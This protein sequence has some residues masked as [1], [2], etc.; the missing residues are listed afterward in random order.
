MSMQP[1]NIISSQISHPVASNFTH[2]SLNHATPS[3][4]PMQPVNQPSQV[5][6]NAAAA[7][8][9]QLSSGIGHRHNMGYEALTINQLRADQNVSGNANRLLNSAVQNVPPL[10]PLNDMGAAAVSGSNSSTNVSTVDQLFAATG[11]FS[12]KNQLRQDNINAITFAY[13]SFKH[14]EAAKLGLINMSDGEFLARLR[15]LK[16]T[17]EIACLSS[18]LA[19]F[20]DQAW[21]VAREYD[22]RVVSD[23]E[24]GVKTWDT[25]SNGLETDALYCANQIIEL[26]IK[27]KKGIKDVKKDDAVKKD[28]GKTKACTTFNTHR[29]SEGCAWEQRNEGESCVFKHFCSWCKA[30]RD[31]EEK[32]KAFQCEHKTE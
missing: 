25:L 12:Y 32:H 14:L 13:G 16:N 31:V 19:S 2:P 23:I 29:S 7:L 8:N 17:F 28:K 15:H 10:N 6:A 11:Q 5:V 1:S 21:Q 27:S 26:K 22:T 18:N 20:S 4:G 9:A 24:S 30:N 3:L